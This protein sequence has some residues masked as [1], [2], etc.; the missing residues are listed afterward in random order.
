[1]KSILKLSKIK[2]VDDVAVLREAVSHNEGVIACQVSALK[3]EISIVYDDYFLK[4]EDL[5]QSIEEAGF[6]VI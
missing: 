3:N 4:E 6:T 5:I 2:S 1:M